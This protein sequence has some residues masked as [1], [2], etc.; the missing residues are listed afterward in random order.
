MRASRP[1]SASWLICDQLP[2]EAR[3]VGAKRQSQADSHARRT[4]RRCAAD[5]S[6]IRDPPPLLRLPT[7]N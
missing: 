4:V 3:G 2:D 1:V 5:R 7:R 6:Y